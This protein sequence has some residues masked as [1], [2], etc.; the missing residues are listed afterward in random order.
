G[1]GSLAESTDLT[2][3]FIDRGPVVQV[4]DSTGRL[5]IERDSDAGVTYDGPLAVLVNRASASASEIFAAAIQDYGRG[6]VIG[7]TTFGKGTVQNLVDLDHVAD[8]EKPALGQLK[9][10]I[11][12][13]FR[14]NGKSTQHRGVVPDVLFPNSVGSEEYGESTFDNALPYTEISALDF[15]PASKL[16]QLNEALTLRHGQRAKSDEELRLYFEEVEEYRREREDRTVSL[17]LAKRQQERD[18]QERREKARAERLAAIN[19]AYEQSRR[20]AL[21]DGLNP[22][23]EGSRFSA[24]VDEEEEESRPDV[25]LTEAARILGDAIEIGGSVL[26]AQVGAA[27]ADQATR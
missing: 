25:L 3:L 23:E 11:A 13:F 10:T 19:E 14:V 6:L 16:S 1:G 18:E 20:P 22:G 24:I 4:R 26:T 7:E 8:S 15:A 21:D 12:Q 27:T 17:N 5:Q 9:M 2:G